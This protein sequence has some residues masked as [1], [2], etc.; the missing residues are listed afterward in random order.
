MHKKAEKIRTS[1]RSEAGVFAQLLLLTR[2]KAH[3]RGIK[4]I[5]PFSKEWPQ[6]KEVCKL[7]TEFCN[8]FGISIKEGYKAYLE[9]AVKMMKNF[10]LNK[11]QS[12][13]QAICT[14][15]ESTEEIKS[16]RNPEKTKE[17]YIFYIKMINEK[18]GWDYND[19]ESNPEKYVCF[20]RA[21]ANAIKIGVSHKTYIKAQFAGLEFGEKQ[22]IP[23]PLQL[24][25]DKA[26]QR[27]R[28]YCFNNDISIQQAKGLDFKKIKNASK[29]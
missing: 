27:V 28:K 26:I 1:G 8:E 25:G 29:A 13:H 23:D 7:A 22:N 16:D 17:L 3:H 9:I 10:T 20:V 24:Y 6:L 19:Y 2:R 5:E 4:L 14:H 11:F 21:S 12:L 15:Y 18:V